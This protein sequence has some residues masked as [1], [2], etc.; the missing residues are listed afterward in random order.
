MAL[1]EDITGITGVGG[2]WLTR[3]AAFRHSF[4]LT[5]ETGESGELAAS[6]RSLTSP[7]CEKYW[8]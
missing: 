4:F 1:L 5:G 2:E 3:S 7:V 8:F 6:Q